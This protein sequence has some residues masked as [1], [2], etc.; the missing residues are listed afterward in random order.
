MTD[1]TLRELQ[2]SLPWTAHY[3]RDFRA[4]PM[5]HKDFGHGLTHVVK[6]AGKLAAIVDEAEHAGHDFNHAEVGKYLADLVICALRM[7]NTCPNGVVDLQRTVEDRLATK[8]AA[9]G[10]VAQ[11]LRALEK[12]A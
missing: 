7:A 6:A 1:R 11:R 4:T 10:D 2:S 12:A 5:S 3:H 9:L 8:N